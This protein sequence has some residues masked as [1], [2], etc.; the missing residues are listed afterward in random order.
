MVIPFKAALN[1]S[2]SLSLRNALGDETLPPEFP[3]HI[4]SNS[5]QARK[6]RISAGIFC[7]RQGAP[8]YGKRKGM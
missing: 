5:C 4:Q 6:T 1:C 8:N 3:F 2:M 7:A